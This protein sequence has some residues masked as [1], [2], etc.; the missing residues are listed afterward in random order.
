MLS[1]KEKEIARSSKFL[2]GESGYWGT[3]KD[4]MCPIGAVALERGVKFNTYTTGADYDGYSPDFRD[5]ENK[6]L[7]LSA[8]QDV[9]DWLDFSNCQMFFSALET[10]KKRIFDRAKY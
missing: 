3:S 6:N 4:G 7:F 10:Y 9:L 1:E 5:Y 2:N 8:Q